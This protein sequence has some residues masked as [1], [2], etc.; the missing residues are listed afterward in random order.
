MTACATVRPFASQTTAEK[1]IPSRTTVECAVR[2]IVVAISS[3]ID[4]SALPTIWSVTGSTRV[5][6]AIVAAPGR[7]CRW[8]R[9]GG[10]TSRAGRRRS[11]RTRRRAAGPAPAP[12]RSTTRVR[13]GA[14][15][16]VAA[17]VDPAAR[18]AGAAPFAPSS[19]TSASPA[20]R[21]ERREPQRPDLDRR[22]GLV[23]DAVEPLVLVLEARPQR[24]EHAARRSAPAGKPTSTSQLWPP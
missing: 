12:R 6:V 9:R 16:L 19:G 11:C 8:P 4:A 18:A 2:K 24:G 15:T 13:T 17:E 1:S 14:S 3:A 23:R 7:A 20:R 21:A 5:L 10:P 22:A